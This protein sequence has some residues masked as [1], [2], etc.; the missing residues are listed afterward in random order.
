MNV[1]D[2]RVSVEWRMC[3]QF[4]HNMK[5]LHSDFIVVNTFI[6]S[7]EEINCV[8]ERLS[9]FHRSFVLS[10]DMLVGFRQ[11]LAL[12]VYTEPCEKVSF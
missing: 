2:T 5:L 12:E 9:W 1:G 7:R 6:C 8:M 10:P 3:F 4:E 11:V